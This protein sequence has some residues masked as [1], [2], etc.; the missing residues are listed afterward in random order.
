MNSKYVLSAVVASLLALTACEKKSAMEQKVDDALG[1]RTGE[2]IR[3][4]AE[5]L[6]AAAKDLG[7]AVSD[8]A[9]DAAEE[10][11]EVAAAVSDDVQDAAKKV[12]EAAQDATG[13]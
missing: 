5:D 13:N 9:K 8:S 2:E 6:G 4:A 3:D 1:Q 12:Q 7:E 10:A 11:K